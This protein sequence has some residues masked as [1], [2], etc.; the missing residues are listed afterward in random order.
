MK[1]INRIKEL[2]ILED[3]YQKSNKESQFLVL[4]GQRRI[5]KTEL[6]KK[7][8]DQKSGV[9]FLAS[10]VSAREE[11][12][13]ATE[14]FAEFFGDKYLDRNRFLNWRELFDYLGDKLDELK[15]SKPVILI[16]DE[17]PFLASSEPGISSLFQY[18]W[19]EVLRHKNVF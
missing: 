13:M 11:L 18:G 9:Y 8:L 4:Y 10:K 5:G 1:F 7:F 17:F 12:S 2:Q 3:L 19:D 14:Q 6:V 15:P 16:F